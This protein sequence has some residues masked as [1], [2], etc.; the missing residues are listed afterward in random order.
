MV[1]C[2]EKRN[3]SQNSL[4]K[5][6]HKVNGTTLLESYKPSPEHANNLEKPA[7]KPVQYFFLMLCLLNIFLKKVG[8]ILSKLYFPRL[9]R[10]K[11]CA[12]S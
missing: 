10:L 11:V 9:H 1:K 6:K 12:K 3:R 2:K 8:S 5:G 4:F 7:H